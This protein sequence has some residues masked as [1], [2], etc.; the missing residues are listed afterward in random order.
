MSGRTTTLG[1][2]PGGPQPSR[3]PQSRARADYQPALLHRVPA[4]LYMADAGEFGAWR[5]VSPQIDTILGY[6]PEEWCADPGLWAQPPASGRPPPGDRGRGADRRRR[7]AAES[8]PNTG[9]CTV[10]GTWSG[11]ATTRCWWR[12]TDGNRCWHGV[13]SDIGSRSRPRPSSSAARRNRRR[14]RGLG[15]HALEGARSVGP[16]AGGGH[17]PPDSCS[18]VEIAIVT[19]ARSRARRV[20]VPRQVR[21]AGALDQPD[22]P[23]TG[24]GIAGSV[25]PAVRSGAP[26]IVT[27][28]EL[29]TRFARLPILPSVGAQRPDGEDR[30][31]RATRSA[32]SACT[33]PRR[34]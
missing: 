2:T 33:A 17:V 5:Y 24:R 19:R 22:R 20:R 27:D 8:Q 9:C 13:M 6:S 30:G 34:D 14:S 28:W 26:V 3:T 29:E 23:R 31:R 25:H 21:L 7:R 32:C 18:T 16:D 12:Q 11:S 10:T 1:K 15:E 4:I